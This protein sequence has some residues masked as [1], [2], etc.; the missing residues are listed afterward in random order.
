MDSAGGLERGNRPQQGSRHLFVWDGRDRGMNPDIIPINRIIHKH[1]VFSK[2]PPFAN[3]TPT[4]VAAKVLL[5][6]RPKRPKDPVLI[7]GLWDLTQ[8][9][10]DQ[11]PRR[12]PEISEIVRYLQGDLILQKDHVD[13]ETSGN[14]QQWGSSPCASSF[15]APPEVTPTRSKGTR[16]SMLAYRPWRRCKLNKSS[17]FVSASDTAYDIKSKGSGHSLH[18][19]KFGASDTPVGVQPTPSGSGSR[20]LLQRAICWISARARAPPAWDHHSCPS[21]SPEKQGMKDVKK[22]FLELITS[23]P[24]GTLPGP[25]RGAS[26]LKSS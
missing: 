9:C 15:I 3:S 1:K 22:A 25:N 12:R 4:S 13:E 14:T 17:E 19:I 18:H 2:A 6:E 21:S 20:G 7:D 26:Y 24:V 16:R 5:G 10:L 11:N 8:R 23:A